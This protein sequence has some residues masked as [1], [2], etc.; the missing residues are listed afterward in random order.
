MRVLSKVDPPAPGGKSKAPMVIGIIVVLALLI[1]GAFVVLGG[2]DD[3]GDDDVAAEDE[4]TTTT[5][6]DDAAT[7]TT[8]PVVDDAI[9]FAQALDETGVLV[10]EVPDFWQLD[11]ATLS[12][13]R[14]NI[15][16]GEDIAAFANGLGS[17]GLS[18][19]RLPEPNVDPNAGIDFLASQNDLFNIC[20]PQERT[21]YTLSL[22]HI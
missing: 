8:A 7:T 14:P 2:G 5:E 3:D 22:I 11:G 4:E 19:T 9:T 21:D 16:A 17:S 15:L 10:V 20:E 18:Y 13:G 12:D 6:A 1:G